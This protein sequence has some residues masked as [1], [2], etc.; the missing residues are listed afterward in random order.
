MRGREA[1]TEVYRRDPEGWRI[2][3]THWS[4]LKPQLAQ[5]EG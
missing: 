1:A 3:H 4:F 5:P 2:I